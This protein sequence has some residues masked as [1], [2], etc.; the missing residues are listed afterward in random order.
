[1]FAAG[2]MAI[3]VYFTY[4]LLES[5]MPNKIATVM[6]IAMAGLLYL[7]L[8]FAFVLKKDD[9]AFLPGGS[10]VTRVMEKLKIW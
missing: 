2:V 5:I 3:F 8:V 1:L 6:E 7:I 9:M 10:R 4:P